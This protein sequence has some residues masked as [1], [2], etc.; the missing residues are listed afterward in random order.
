MKLHIINLQE[1]TD[2]RYT[3]TQQ[4]REKNL[5]HQFISGI[6]SNGSL[7]PGKS[8]CKCIDLA[9]QNQMKMILVCED[10]ILLKEDT[11]SR[12]SDIIKN[13]PND[14]DLFLGGA[15]GLKNCTKINQEIFKVGEFSG[16]HFVVYR[17]KS[18]DKVLSWLNV[19]KSRK[20]RR[21]SRCPHIDIFLGKM[22]LKK[23]LNIYAPFNFLVDTYD[24][25]SDVRK[26]HTSDKSL[27]DKVKSYLDSVI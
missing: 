10:D 25:Y 16:L 2:R 21:F 22:S 13:L 1:R 20:F 19:K 26:I 3:M 11:I 23:E 8:H 15:S 7:G 14:W 6:K 9:I 17:E 5:D 27:F 4:L 18:Y 24:S 12:L